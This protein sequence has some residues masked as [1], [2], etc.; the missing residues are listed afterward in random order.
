MKLVLHID[1]LVMRGVPARE[2]EAMLASLQTALA[3]ELAQPGVADRWAA[4]PNRDR[5]QQRFTPAAGRLAE[6]AAKA[7]VQ[8]SRR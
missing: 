2:R 1:R 4:S 8:G 5:V 6:D 7:L 3:H